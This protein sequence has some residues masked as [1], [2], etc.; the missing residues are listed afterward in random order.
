VKVTRIWPTLA[1]I[2]RWG[3]AA[4]E[5]LSDHALLYLVVLAEESLPHVMR[6]DLR[7]VAA[8]EMSRRGLIVFRGSGW[9]IEP[10]FG[11]AALLLA[12]LPIRA[13][14]IAPPIQESL[15]H[16]AP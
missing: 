10:R 6:P 16:A 12:P 3:T 8:Q 13:R 5:A 15:A 7:D 9:A 14:A 11:R 1:E 2:D 4:R